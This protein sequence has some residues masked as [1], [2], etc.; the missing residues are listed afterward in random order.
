MQFPFGKWLYT[1]ILLGLFVFLLYVRWVDSSI[2][3]EYFI[4]PFPTAASITY[5][6]LFF[7]GGLWSIRRWLLSDAID[8][9]IFGV[10]WT[11]L[12]FYGCGFSLWHL[13]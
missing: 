1:P 3:H 5:A 6:V 4:S 2:I 11:A 12:M 7:L 8:D 10:F 9:R 13:K